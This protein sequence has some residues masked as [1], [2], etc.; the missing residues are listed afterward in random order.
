MHDPQAMC[1]VQ[2]GG[3]LRRGVES[4]RE[5]KSPASHLPPQRLT[6][7]ELGRDV[8]CG[9]FL[10]D[11]KNSDDVGVI[12]RGRR[13]RLLLEAAQAV[14]VRGEFVGQQLER[15]LPPKPRVA[16]EGKFSPPARAQQT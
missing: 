14:V 7:N 2:G 15:D 6:V 13:A 16:G 8:V 11:L 4:E 9:A 5:I 10:S 1:G 12:E 3:G